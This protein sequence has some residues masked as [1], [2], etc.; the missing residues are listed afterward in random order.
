M[1]FEVGVKWKCYTLREERIKTKRQILSQHLVKEGS[2]VSWHGIE[3][4]LY[5]SVELETN[6][7]KAGLRNDETENHMCYRACWGLGLEK[8]D[9]Q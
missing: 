8:H 1:N 9:S 5:R 6:L 3:G 7:Q 2:K 4:R